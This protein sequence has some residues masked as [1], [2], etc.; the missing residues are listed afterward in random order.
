MDKTKLLEYWRQDA[1][2]SGIYSYPAAKINGVKYLGNLD[3][4]DILEMVCASLKSPP[5]TGCGV[6]DYLDIVSNKTTTTN[7]YFILWVVLLILVVAGLIFLAVYI[8][9][10][11][12]KKEITNEMSLKVTE[13]VSQYIKLASDTEKKNRNK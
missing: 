7:V 10:K 3:S 8:Y 13:M 2:V 11:T 9:R 5:E 4:E 12:V 1:I 6:Y